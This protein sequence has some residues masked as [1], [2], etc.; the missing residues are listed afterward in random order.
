MSCLPKEITV[1]TIAGAA[2]ILLADTNAEATTTVSVGNDVLIDLDRNGEL[3][4][5]ELLNPP[6]TW[7]TAGSMQA[8]D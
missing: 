6:S 7:L 8:N 3:V 2:Y 1:D 5:I 4:G